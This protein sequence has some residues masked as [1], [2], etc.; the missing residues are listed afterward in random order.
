MRL[1]KLKKMAD[2]IYST[3]IDF[4][5]HSQKNPSQNKKITAPD[6]HCILTDTPSDLKKSFMKIF[7][8]E[9]NLFSKQQLLKLKADYNF[10]LLLSDTG[11]HG[12]D[13]CHED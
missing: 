7:L 13:V 12:M 6:F 10:H 3:L 4:T 2:T 5:S 8:I 1:V 11:Y 9:E